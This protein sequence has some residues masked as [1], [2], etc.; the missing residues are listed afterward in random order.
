MPPLHLALKTT[1]TFPSRL[2]A[3]EPPLEPRIPA[4]PPQFAGVVATPVLPLGVT[5][6]FDILPGIGVPFAIGDFAQKHKGA[7]CVSS[8]F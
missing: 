2:G 8:F 4:A 6:N 7:L 3:G 1:R 5:A